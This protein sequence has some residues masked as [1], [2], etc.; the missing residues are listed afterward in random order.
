MSE[1]QHERWSTQGM[2]CG[3]DGVEDEGRDRASHSG[4]ADE[5]RDRGRHGCREYGS[6]YTPR[7]AAVRHVSGHAPNPGMTVVN[8]EV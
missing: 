7:R 4:S 6:A 2:E 3:M 5:G 1:A 8:E